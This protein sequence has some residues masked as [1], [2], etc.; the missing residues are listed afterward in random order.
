[1][2]GTLS[3]EVTGE[4]LDKVAT[5]RLR[6]AQDATDTD[7]ADGT[8]TV[9]GDASKAKVTFQIPKLG[10]LEK[11]AYKVYMVSTTGVES[12]ANQ[13]LHFD[14]NPFVTELSPASFD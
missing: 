7:T 14:L 8:V 13:T 4:G 1:K 6:N 3:C 10:G 2:T 5:L 11:P 9:S 12:F